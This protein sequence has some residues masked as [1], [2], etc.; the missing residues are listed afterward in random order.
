M[1]THG[2]KKTNKKYKRWHIVR[3]QKEKKKTKKINCLH[4]TF[5][6]SFLTNFMN[7]N[8]IIIQKKSYQHE[9]K[10]KR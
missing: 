3:N 8:S 5:F 10:Q 1:A 4:L 9:I 6:I 7:N 2:T